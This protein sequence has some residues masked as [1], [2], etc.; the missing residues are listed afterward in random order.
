MPTR[1]SPVWKSRLPETAPAWPTGRS[2][3]DALQDLLQKNIELAEKRGFEAIRTT[4]EQQAGQYGPERP[5]VSEE[6]GRPLCARLDGGD[7]A[8]GLTLTAAGAGRLQKVWVL[9][10]AWLGFLLLVGLL[11]LLWPTSFLPRWFWPEQ[12][13][14]IGLVGW[15][16]AGPTVIVLVLILLAIGA[17]VLILMAAARRFFWHTT[18][19][20][21][22][23]SA[24]LPAVS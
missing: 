21:S 20:Q 1:P 8:P 10:W 17:R 13:A 19:D 6:E 5:G 11:S 15:W 18:A 16:A 24:S 22:K 12:I 14:L 7:Q 9:T 2:P 23:S 3:L 4:A